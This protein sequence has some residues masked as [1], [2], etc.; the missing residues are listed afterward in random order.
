MSSSNAAANG[1]TP[2]STL[3]ITT[4]WERPFVDASGGEAILLV[5]IAAAT[6]DSPAGA[7]RR[8]P[9]DVAF[10]LDRSGS[11]AGE[12]L[13]LVKEAV[14]VAVAHLSDEDRAAL[15]IYD[16]SVNVLQGL[17]SATA[18]AKTTLRLALHGVDPGGSTNLS[19]GWLTGCQ[20]LSRDLPAPGA[21]PANQPV[22]LR[23]SLLLTDGLANV[24]ITN[25][26]AL[27]HHARELR[28][29]G[30]ATTTLGVGLDF[31]EDLLASMAEAG[32]GNFQ[33]IEQPSQLRAFFARELG[34]LLTVVAADLNLSLTLPHGL[35]ARLLNLFPVNREGN[36][37]DIAIGD[38]PASDEIHLIFAV[39]ARAGVT[40]ASHLVQ[41]DATWADPT[42]DRRQSVSQILPPLVLADRAT[43]EATPGDQIVAE[44]AGL[45]RAAAAQREAMRL[46][47]AGRFAESRA[48][49]RAAA[50]SLAMAPPTT[51]VA[52]RL[53]MAQQY[54][55]YDPTVAYDESTRKRG[56]YDAHRHS[57]G[58]R[59]EQ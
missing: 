12:K 24:G 16:D 42:A 6:S 22:R 23:R 25:P 50:Q 30:I 17:T 11:M 13:D 54:A 48:H 37:L 39:T 9:V 33:F 21:S 10:V 41:L 34:E 2:S 56:A 58:K 20:E 43:V 40:G 4:A 8:A 57:R 59:D 5:R 28:Q 38:L 51:M 31:D 46:D 26:A 15:V 19:D 7:S 52:E 47:R 1:A 14:D 45:Q 29:R 49:M 55:D 27:A 35:R 32:G 3:S 44:Q 36:R 18:R 53:A